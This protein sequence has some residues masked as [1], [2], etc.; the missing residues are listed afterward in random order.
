MK[1]YSKNI[2]SLDINSVE[3]IIRSPEY[4]VLLCDGMEERLEK[5]RS[6]KAEQKEEEAE[7]GK[8]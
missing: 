7:Y 4:N 1:D 2:T 6:K 5:V 8:S 3:K